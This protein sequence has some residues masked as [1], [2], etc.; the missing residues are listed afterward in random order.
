MCHASQSSGCRRSALAERLDQ[1]IEDRAFETVI[2][3]PGDHRTRNNLLY[4][5]QPLY[6]D[7]NILYAAKLNKESFCRAI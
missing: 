2:T 3:K 1:L 7:M 6:G 5:N 4:N